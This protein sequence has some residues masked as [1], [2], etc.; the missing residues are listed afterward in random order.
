[1]L[2]TPDVQLL[3]ER[4]FWGQGWPQFEQKLRAYMPKYYLTQV[5]A[6]TLQNDMYGAFLAKA[7]GAK[8]IAMGTHVT[9]MAR[10]TLRAYPS[11]DY[12]LRGEPELT[13]RELIDT[14]EVSRGRWR[15]VDAAGSSQPVFAAK[16]RDT[17]VVAQVGRDKQCIV[18]QGDRGFGKARTARSLSSRADAANHLG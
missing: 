10:E 17:R 16:F 7:L 5:T 6:P 8:T 13:L 14:L 15:V 4:A 2:P 3:V 18:D 9:P 1:V 11:L 12:V